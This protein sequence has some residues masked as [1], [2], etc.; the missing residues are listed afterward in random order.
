MPVAFCRTGYSLLGR[1][2]SHAHVW[3][4]CTRHIRSDP[5]LLSLHTCVLWNTYMAEIALCYAN[6]S[7]TVTVQF[8]TKLDKNASYT[9]ANVT[10]TGRTPNKD[11]PSPAKSRVPRNLNAQPARRPLA[12]CRA[13]WHLTAKR[14]ASWSKVHI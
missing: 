3:H 8:E 1:K 5:C 4:S 10:I 14:A 13:P 2:Q 12:R 6:P 7:V 11:S 9:R